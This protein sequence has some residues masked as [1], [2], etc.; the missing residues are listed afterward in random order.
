MRKQPPYA[1]LSKY[2]EGRE[3]SKVVT[4]WKSFY[5][6]EM[7]NDLEHNFEHLLSEGTPKVAYV[8][9][10]LTISWIFSEKGIEFIENAFSVKVPRDV[11]E[12]ERILVWASEY[13]QM[14]EDNILFRS[15]LSQEESEIVFNGGKGN[16]V[17]VADTFVGWLNSYVGRL[18]VKKAFSK[19]VREHSEDGTE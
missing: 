5:R 9:L 14:F 8:N 17:V 4:T 12:S 6:E 15:Q 7:L 19:D 11:E 18:F 1:D 2:R 13:Q 16:H 10:R 3:E